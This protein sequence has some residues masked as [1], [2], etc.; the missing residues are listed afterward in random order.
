M[1]FYEQF[2]GFHALRTV[3]KYTSRHLFRY[4]EFTLNELI[5]MTVSLK[6]YL[7]RENSSCTSTF[8]IYNKDIL[9]L[10]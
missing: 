9:V 1:R 10:I 7:P 8:I 2:Y 5:T 4:S 3:G 6:S